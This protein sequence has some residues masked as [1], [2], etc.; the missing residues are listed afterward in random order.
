LTSAQ[1]A[2]TLSL[3]GSASAPLWAS[4]PAA[5]PQTI[6]LCVRQAKALL[7]L[8]SRGTPGLSELKGKHQ[9]QDREVW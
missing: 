2:V 7:C 1:W 3:N 9:K 5:Q 6:I 8:E 4:N